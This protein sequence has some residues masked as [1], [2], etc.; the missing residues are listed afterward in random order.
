MD[1]D[2]PSSS[3]WKMGLD[4]SGR[5]AFTWWCSQEIPAAEG[6]FT[7]YH[8]CLNV[9]WFQWP[10]LVYKGMVCLVKTKVRD[11]FNFVTSH[12]GVINTTPL[13]QMFTSPYVLSYF[14]TLPLTSRVPPNNVLHN[15]LSQYLLLRGCNRQHCQEI[16]VA[17]SPW[18]LRNGFL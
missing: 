5:S 4:W 3:P 18:V 16:K 14:L 7:E 9:T 1:S 15:K 13:P 10:R 12:T 11:H 6:H 2:V 17:G 8:T